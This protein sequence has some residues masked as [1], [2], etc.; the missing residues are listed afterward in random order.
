MH[1]EPAVARQVQQLPRQQAW[2]AGHAQHV[3]PQVVQGRERLRMREAADLQHGNAV[4]PRQP[5]NGGLRSH[6]DERQSVRTPPWWQQNAQ[7][8]AVAGHARGA[9]DHHGADR[10]L[11]RQERG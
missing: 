2:E 7:R 6:G 1:V 5:D 11:R 9:R 10:A 4:R 3:R 8:R